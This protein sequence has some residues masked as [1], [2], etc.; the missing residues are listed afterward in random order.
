MEKWKTRVKK[1]KKN[2]F[3][4]RRRQQL[5]SDSYRKNR[6]RAAPRV[7][8]LFSPCLP[9]LHPGALVLDHPSLSAK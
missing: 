5:E 4:D 9:W 2:R 7:D 6:A 8:S 3:D 1:K